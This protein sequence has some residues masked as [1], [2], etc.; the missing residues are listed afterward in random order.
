MYTLEQWQRI[1]QNFLIFFYFYFFTGNQIRNLHFPGRPIV[2]LNQTPRPSF[3][4]FNKQSV[5]ACV[6]QVH[7]HRL[8]VSVSTVF[9]CLSFFFF[10]FETGSHCI[11]L[12]GLECEQSSCLCVCTSE[13]LRLQIWATTRG[14]LCFVLCFLPA[15]ASI[16]SHHFSLQEFGTLC[17]AYF[18]L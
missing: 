10:C 5:A 13:V 4:T 2:P 17:F 15:S 3:R 9:V 11:A 7:H 12:L 1:F 8:K 18:S 6:S 14:Q 16:L